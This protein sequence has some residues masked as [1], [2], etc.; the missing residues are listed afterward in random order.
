MSAFAFHTTPQM[1][2]R[3]G[4]SGE[5]ADI[6]G[7]R[8]GDRILFVT[9]KGI[10]NAGLEKQAIHRSRAPATPLPSSMPWRPIPALQP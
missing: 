2:V 4:A 10:R 8:L 3:P 9:D 7:A 5:L 6:A 1:I